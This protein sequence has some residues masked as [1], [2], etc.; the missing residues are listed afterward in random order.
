MRHVRSLTIFEARGLKQPRIHLV[1]SQ[2]P[3][4]FFFTVLQDVQAESADEGFKRSLK[5]TWYK[6]Q[7]PTRC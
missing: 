2:E 5:C 6:P 3:L 7:Q 1:D 4:P